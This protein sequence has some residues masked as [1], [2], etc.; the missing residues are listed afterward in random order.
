MST[1]L[2]LLILT[3]SPRWITVGHVRAERCK[4]GVGVRLAGSLGKTAVPQPRMSG[5]VSLTF[6]ADRRSNAS[7]SS[8]ASSALLGAGPNASGDLDGWFDSWIRSL[9][10]V[11]FGR[12]VEVCSRQ[13]FSLDVLVPNLL[14]SI[15]NDGPLGGKFKC[16]DGTSNKK[17]RRQPLDPDRFWVLL[18]VFFTIFWMIS[19]FKLACMQA[20]ICCQACI[21]LYLA[22]PQWHWDQCK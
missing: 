16:N 6:E 12:P 1:D 18:T 4:S 10:C 3:K 14:F 19:C 8:E 11:F 20:N 9:F 17:I 15:K 5:I 22:A 13:L 2:L 21:S 7:C